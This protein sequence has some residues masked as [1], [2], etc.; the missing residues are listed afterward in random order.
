MHKF[1]MV[2]ENL[3]NSDRVVII[4]TG[5]TIEKTY[6]EGDGSLQNRESIVKN[7]IQNKLRLP[8]TSMEVYSVMSKDSLHMDD[9]DRDLLM[10]SIKSQLSKEI[11]IVILHGT[12][13]MEVSAKYCF[14]KIRATNVPI[15][16]TG[17]MKPLGFEDSDAMQNITES[18][19]AAKILRPG[20]YIVFHNRVFIV[21]NVRKNRQLRTFEAI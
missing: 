16:F 2:N 14:E 8:Y 12:D 5:G 11:P 19:L 13:T 9:D 18:M 20:F 1:N 6:D 15:I 10:L 4:T 3:N 21:P 17:A 7:K